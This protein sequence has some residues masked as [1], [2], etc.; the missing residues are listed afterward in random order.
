M[1]TTYNFINQNVNVLKIC[2]KIMKMKYHY[3]NLN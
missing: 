2:I 1:K 3:L